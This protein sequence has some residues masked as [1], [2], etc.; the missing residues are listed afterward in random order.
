MTTEIDDVGG[1]A[2]R[3][4]CI[5]AERLRTA[6]AGA[7]LTQDDVAGALGISRSAVSY[8][9]A[10]HRKVSAV[11][12]GRLGRLYRRDVWWLLG[13]DPDPVDDTVARVVRGLDGPDRELV[14]RFAQFLAS[15]AGRRVRGASARDVAGCDRCTP[16]E[17][18]ACSEVGC[19]PWLHPRDAHHLDGS[20][21]A[22][23]A[24][25]AS[26]ELTPET[27][28]EQDAHTVAMVLTLGHQAVGR[29]HLTDEEKRAL[30]EFGLRWRALHPG[31]VDDLDR[32]RA[33]AA[34]LRR[35]I[36]AR[37]GEAT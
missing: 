9:E 29:L 5:L 25:V 3:P 21:R 13:Q 2:R 33:R 24:R 14:L 12:L 34:E 36:A 15:P 10:G 31:S 8:L 1:A 18:R 27:A 30:A 26:G 19:S 32:V 37:R 17:A 20:W 11:E 35:R 4:E 28:T 22:V 7:G 16:E 23:L 6:R